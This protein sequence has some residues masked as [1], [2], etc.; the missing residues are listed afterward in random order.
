M[1]MLTT[2][3]STVIKLQHLRLHLELISAW[4]LMKT[5]PVGRTV[6]SQLTQEMYSHMC[7]QT[8]IVNKPS[9]TDSARCLSSRAVA[10][11]SFHLRDAFGLNQKQIDGQKL[12]PA[13]PV[14]PARGI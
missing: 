12:A 13:R 4:M 14:T 1:E 6:L 7:R 8:M 5:L 3:I 2:A 11:P 9:M 10:S